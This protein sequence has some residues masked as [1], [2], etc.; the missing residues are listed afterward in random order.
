MP[1][2]KTRATRIIWDIL[3][4]GPGKGGNGEEE[5]RFR[6]VRRSPT[7]LELGRYFLVHPPTRRFRPK[8]LPG[9]TVQA[10]QTYRMDVENW[11]CMKMMDAVTEDPQIDDEPLFHQVLRELQMLPWDE[12][13]VE[14]GFFLVQPCPQSL[15]KELRKT[16]W[17][18]QAIGTKELPYVAAKGTGWWMAVEPA[19]YEL[20]KTRFAFINLRRMTE[21]FTEAALCNRQIGELKPRQLFRLVEAATLTAK[22][23]LPKSSLEL[24]DKSK[25]EDDE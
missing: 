1:P 8:D 5:V 2:A 18:L 23:A 16:D 9:Q 14:K 10:L 25:D 6:K 15:H 24:E 4:H 3:V 13:V 11:V 22:K 12:G 17:P 21:Q 7:Y 20:W 19:D